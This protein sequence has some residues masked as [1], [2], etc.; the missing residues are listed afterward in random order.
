MTVWPEPSMTWNMDEDVFCTSALVVPALI[1]RAEVPK[2][3]LTTN[4]LDRPS[5]KV[6]LDLLSEP[7]C[8]RYG[9]VAAGPSSLSKLSFILAQGN[10]IGEAEE[11]VS[12][13]GYLGS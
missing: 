7:S 8:L 2:V 12:S 13:A 3:L 10:T 11:S 4:M 1:L 9:S 5:Q 6:A